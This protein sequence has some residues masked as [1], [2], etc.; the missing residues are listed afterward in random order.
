[1]VMFAIL[2]MNGAEGEVYFRSLNK[3][4]GLRFDEV[5]CHYIWAHLSDKR[6]MTRRRRTRDA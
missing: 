1:M 3:D 5:Y 6:D 2:K 4:K